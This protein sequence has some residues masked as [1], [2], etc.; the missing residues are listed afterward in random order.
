MKGEE[1]EGT[2]MMHCMHEI[3]HRN[4]L[5]SQYNHHG[6]AHSRT[7]MHKVNYEIICK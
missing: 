1:S 7:N 6:K 3:Q 5:L 2:G 4:C